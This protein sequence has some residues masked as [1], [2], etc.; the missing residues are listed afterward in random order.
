MT[1]E[2]IRD[3]HGDELLTPHSSALVIIDY[4]PG[5]FTQILFGGD[6]PRAGARSE[7]AGN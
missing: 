2:P 3:P 4:Q 7:R 6:R 1:S 5:G